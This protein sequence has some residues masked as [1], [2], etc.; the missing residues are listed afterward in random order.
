MVTRN[1]WRCRR[2]NAST[3]VVITGFDC[4]CKKYRVTNRSGGIYCWKCGKTSPY[5]DGIPLFTER[6]TKIGPPRRR[7]KTRNHRGI[8]MNSLN[9]QTLKVRCMYSGDDD[10]DGK[11]VNHV[12]MAR[13]LAM[14]DKF[15][16]VL[17][18][19]CWKFASLDVPITSNK[20]PTWCNTV[21]VLFLQCHS[22]CFGRQAPIIRSIKKLARRPV[23][24]VL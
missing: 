4:K 14:C 13:T 21:Q 12:M 8:H 10:D 1:T 24:Q 19:P 23:V 18:L 11:N 20:T 7:R 22:T 6:I 5:A 9:Q 2:G 16:Q 17:L 15:L 3:D